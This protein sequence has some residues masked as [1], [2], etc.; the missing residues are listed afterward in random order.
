MKLDNRIPELAPSCTRVDR[1]RGPKEK[2]LT[3]TDVSI[4][5]VEFLITFNTE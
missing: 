4:K 2:D 3:E 5:N 1:T